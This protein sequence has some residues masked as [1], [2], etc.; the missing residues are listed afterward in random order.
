MQIF[1]WE[2]NLEG[3][4]MQLSE[5]VEI[6]INEIYPYIY[7]SLPRLPARPS[8]NIL[9]ERQFSIVLLLETKLKEGKILT[10]GEIGEICK[11]S[12]SDTTRK[13]KELEKKRLVIRSS[14]SSDDRFKEVS[15]TSEGIKVLSIEKENRKRWFAKIL[16]SLEEKE[17]TFFINI[18]WKILRE[19]K[20]LGK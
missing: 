12:A 13:I 20:V 10:I 9:S 14:L 11:L 16:E 4:K 3:S 6:L 2:I 17:R 18:L 8:P 15:L 1:K 19:Q 7:F 5:G